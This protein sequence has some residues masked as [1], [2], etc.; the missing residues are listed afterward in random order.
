LT[1]D[2]AAG[3]VRGMAGLG[4]FAIN[5]D[6]S[7]E[8]WASIG[9]H[10]GALGWPLVRVPA[11]DANSAD[12]VLSIRALEI[13]EPPHIL[14]LTPH[15]GTK[16]SLAEEACLCS[17]MAALGTF[18]A[19]DL[20]HALVLE[21][22]ATPHPGLVE[23]LSVLPFLI[24]G[25]QLVKL[26]GVGRPGSRRRAITVASLGTFSLV[27]S[28][29]SAYGSA[30]YLV[31]RDAAQ[32]LI[33]RLGKVLMP[34]DIY[35]FASALHGCDVLHMAPWVIRQSSAPSTITG[36]RVR[37]QQ[38]QTLI[39]RLRT[40]AFQA[41]LKFSLCSNALRGLPKLPRKVSWT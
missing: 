22:D 36:I 31:T 15:L 23:V 20:T 5:L 26:E 35:L 29:K 30:G 16:F 27:R 18:L 1:C 33:D 11:I 37:G 13:L 8:R 28:F 4:I 2:S 9:Q 41:R 7:P 25:P 34:A 24:A 40:K 14:G 3:Y 10:F 12:T 19:T 38:A 21:D 6:R 32:R 17:H 39:P